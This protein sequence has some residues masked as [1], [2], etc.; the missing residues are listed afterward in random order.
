MCQRCSEQNTGTPMNIKFVSLENDILF[1]WYK[2][3]IEKS[4]STLDKTKLQNGKLDFYKQEFFKQYFTHFLSIEKLSKGLEII[5]KGQADEIA[6]LPSVAVL[7]RAC[8]ENYSMFFYIYRDSEHY[9]EKE[10]RFWSWYR[11][12][13]MNRQR[14]KVKYFTEK[15]DNEKNR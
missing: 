5:L 10:F 15:K 14:L 11:E 8:I 7:L 4:I 6:A 13:L 2:G 12:G 1:N 9:E 3:L